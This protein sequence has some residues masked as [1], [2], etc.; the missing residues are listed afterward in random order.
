[1]IGE[2]IE[3]V[4]K[5]CY[6]DGAF[7]V[8]YGLGRMK[9]MMKSGK[10][11]TAWLISAVMFLSVLFS[12]NVY[13]ADNTNTD[14]S[15]NNVNVEAEQNAGNEN[16]AIPEENSDIETQGNPDDTA[17]SEQAETAGDTDQTV[18]DS[19]APNQTET[20]EDVVPAEQGLLNYVGVDYPYLETPADQNIVISYGDGS[21]D[22]S[23]ARLVV[24][25]DDGNTLEMSLSK[26]EGELFLFTYSFDETASGVYELIDFVYTQDGTEETIHL[27]D[28]G[29]ESM[30]GVNEEYPGYGE[31][32]EESSEEV[33][34]QELEM[35]VVDVETGE[36]E[37]ATTDIEKAIEATEEQVGAAQANRASRAAVASKSDNLVVVLDPGHGGYDG[38]ASAN[39]LVEKDLTLKI[40]QYC[41]AELEQYNGVTV[42]MTRTDDRYLDIDER[43]YNARDLGADVL[44]SIHINSS[45]APAAN[46][47]E[48]WYPN[49]NYNGSV[50]VEG[51]NLAQQI[52]NQLVALG[53]TN[54]GIQI[55]STVNDTYPDGSKEDWYG[56][57]RY[58]KYCGFPGIIVEHAFISNPS[59]AAKLAQ[60]SFLRQLGIADATGIANA[61]GLTKGPNIDIESKNDFDGTAKINVSGLGSNG[62]VRIWNE[63]TGASK[64]YTLASGKQAIDFNVGDY[65]GAR[66]TYYVEAFNSIGQSLM[67]KTFYVSK[68]TSST[69][70]VSSDDKEVQYGLGVKFVDEPQ[71][72]TNIQ[73]ATWSENGGQDDLRWYQGS[74]KT[75]GEWSATVDIRD[76]RTEGVYVSDVYVTLADNTMICVGRAN[77]TVTTPTLQVKTDNYNEEAGTFDVIVTDIQSVSGVTSISLPVWCA[78]DQSDIHWYATE[79]QEDGSYK[80]TV[81][82]SNHKYATG[83]YTIHTYIYTENGLQIM[84]GKASQEVR[85]PQMKINVSN[86][87]GKEGSYRLEVTNTGVLGVVKNVQFATWSENGGQDDLRWYQ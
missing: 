18:Q 55:R 67:K 56:I 44:V 17:Q 85:M 72:I 41:K 70:S 71:E 57:I 30:F 35:S 59:D 43:V 19:S 1:M 68:D 21:E 79:K 82:M 20:G 13:A 16:G 62:S 8:D 51:Q 80:A 42:Y 47:A 3:K 65:N 58:S 28:I 5:I 15:Q 73:F 86:P 33:T 45:S 83:N 46:G 11:K 4:I 40:A 39:G 66:G 10:R 31:T 63:E 74:R 53:L 49:A 61:Y 27:A 22:V 9:R 26:K 48:V 38:G 12:G 37:A 75:T 23:D 25:K 36:V 7:K 50:H 60:E 34:A 14:S 32:S 76:H 77:F 29:I 6:T 87:D 52:Q 81:R 2:Q 24:Q 84:G 54:R 64:E 78:A 69:I